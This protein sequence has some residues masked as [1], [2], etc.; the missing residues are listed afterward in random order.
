MRFEVDV[1]TGTVAEH[2]D[3]P[4][5]PV[6][7]AVIPDRVTARQFKIQLHHMGLLDSVE[8]WVAGQDKV[9]RIAYE[10]SG[11][12]VRSD[13]MLLTGLTALGLSSGVEMDAFF[14]AASK[15]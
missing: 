13:P 14:T 7:P 9:V 3:A 10:N 5:L 6:P 1:L 12:F 2:E 8:A 15:L 11:S 4:L